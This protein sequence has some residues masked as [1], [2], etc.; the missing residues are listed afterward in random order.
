MTDSLALGALE[1]LGHAL[2]TATIDQPHDISARTNISYASYI[3]GLTLA[4]AGLGVVHGFASFIG[5]A[6]NI[7]H[8]VICGTLLSEVTRHNIES[9][10]ST[11]PNGPALEKYARASR[12]L[13]PS[14][15]FKSAAPKKNVE[16]SRHLIEILGQWTDQL[17]MPRLG[18][19]GLIFKDIEGIV[20]S[21][22]Q[23]NNPVQLS[24]TKLSQILQSRL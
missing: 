14:F 17:K 2:I 6:F 12:H 23:N 24:T 1:I 9:L 5:G 11:D 3:S 16:A 15:V 22:G 19:Y 8:G 18:S 21:I 10:I 4:N 7:P 20:G 13:S